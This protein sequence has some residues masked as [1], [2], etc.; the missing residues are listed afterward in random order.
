ML[1]FL[2]NP[3]AVITSKVEAAHSS[4]VQQVTVKT[5]ISA[6]AIYIYD[7]LTDVSLMLISRF[8]M[9]QI[10]KFCEHSE[11]EALVCQ[12]LN[13]IQ[14]RPGKAIVFVAS[15]QDCDNITDVSRLFCV[16]MDKYVFL[17][18]T[19]TLDTEINE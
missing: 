7:L 19:H 6:Y 2:P 5:R 15:V 14:R 9:F 18:A 11:R 3:M 12:M 10:A 17:S 1:K 16:S 13:F 8:V 4:H